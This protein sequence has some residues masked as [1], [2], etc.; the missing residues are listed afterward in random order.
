MQHKSLGH[1]VQNL[2]VAPPSMTLSL[3]KER[4]S[5]ESI[6]LLFLRRTK[7]RFNS[8]RVIPSRKE[9]PRIIHEQQ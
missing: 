5:V 4:S 8:I 2:M 3:K 7:D 6:M 1:H 9:L